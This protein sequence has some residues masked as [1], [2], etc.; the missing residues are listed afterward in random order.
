MTSSRPNSNEQKLLPQAILDMNYAFARTAMLVASVRLHLFTHLAEKALS[1]AE[2]ASRT[3]TRRE[4]ME[5][6]L[7]GLE[8]LGLVKGDG[9]TYH[10]TPIADAFLVEGKDSYLGG[11][12]LA[13]V[14]YVPAWFELDQTMRSSVP[15][16]DLGYARTAEAFFAP[17]VVD[18]FPLVFP[19]ARR[20][21][22]E[23]PLAR[24]SDA[25]LSILDVG[26]GSAP[27]SAGFAFQYPS[28]QIT[29]LDFPEVIKQGRKHIAEQ[30]LADRYTWIARDMEEFAYPSHSYDLILCGHVCRFISDERSKALIA[31]LVES[32]RPGGTLLIADVFYAPDHASPPPAITLDLSML[33][34]TQQGRIRTVAEVTS[35]LADAG[36]QDARSFHVAGPFPVV[37]A[38]KG[39][40]L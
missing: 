11:D 18:L 15:Y 7:R 10:L 26:A 8:A 13:M 38:R 21:A 22:S 40:N 6:L 33:V 4:S 5:R 27:W 16:R 17:R 12:T 14:D 39:E 28:A 9:D 36:L 24:S 25:N 19:I 29:A 34:N 37:V 3:Q 35:W 31:K 2:L 1:P 30:G 20:T 23:L 32:L